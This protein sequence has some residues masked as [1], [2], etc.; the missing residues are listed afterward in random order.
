MNGHAASAA[1]ASAR[2]KDLRMIYAVV[3]T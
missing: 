1:H 2:R 3:S